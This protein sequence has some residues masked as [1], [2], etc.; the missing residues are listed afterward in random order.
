[1]LNDIIAQFRGKTP[2]EIALMMRKHKIRGRMGTTYGCPMALLCDGIDTG[3][4]VIG[5]KYMVRTSGTKIE[6]ARTP[7]GVSAFIRKFDLGGYPDLISPP[8]RCVTPPVKGTPGSGGPRHTPRKRRAEA[9]NHLAKLV[10]R[11]GVA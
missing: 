4:Y 9:R 10:S 7:L 3:K 11:F 6:Q 8:P 1:M 5:R 2:D